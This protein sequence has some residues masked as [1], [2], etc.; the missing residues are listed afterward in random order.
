MY[1]GLPVGYLLLNGAF[2]G[3]RLPADCVPEIKP[4]LSRAEWQRMNEL[5]AI[6]DS[7]KTMPYEQLLEAR[8]RLMA[9][10]T[11]RGFATIT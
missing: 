3:D 9:G 8:R 11:R 2:D 10:I 5:H 6:P 1:R 4:R 7:W